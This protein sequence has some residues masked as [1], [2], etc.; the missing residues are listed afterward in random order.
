MKTRKDARNE[1]IA[2]Q[3]RVLRKEERAGR[4]LCVDACRDFVWKC[5]NG[6]ANCVRSYKKMK[7]ALK[8]IDDAQEWLKRL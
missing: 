5:E 1:Q 7:D 2:A 3:K 6:Q 4:G 8:I